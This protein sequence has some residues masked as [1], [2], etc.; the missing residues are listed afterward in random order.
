LLISKILSVTCDNASVNNAMIDRLAILNDD[1][2]GSPNHMRCFAHIINLVV[3]SILK[4]FDVPKKQINQVLDDAETELRILAT[5]LE[6][7]EELATEEIEGD[8]AE[9]DD[10]IDG[11]VDEA[12][13]LEEEERVELRKAVLP[14]RMMLTKACYILCDSTTDNAESS[15]AKPPLP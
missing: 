2:P 11:L 15:C 1:F 7:E 10:N 5:D 12:E 9:T 14:A 3:K 4:Q 8:E 13:H 6:E